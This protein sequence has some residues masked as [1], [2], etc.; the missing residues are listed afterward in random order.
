MC[1]PWRREVLSRLLPIGP[2][3]A[4]ATLAT[5][6]HIFNLPV[7]PTWHFQTDRKPDRGRLRRRKRPRLFVDWII[8]IPISTLPLLQAREG[9]IT[10]HSANDCIVVTL[11]SSPAD[12]TTRTTDVSSNRV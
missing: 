11:I 10:C 12:A 4:T 8:R 2:P 5:C 3:T 6:N 1:H 7:G 9:S